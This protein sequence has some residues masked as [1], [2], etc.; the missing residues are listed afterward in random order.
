MQAWDQ[1][2]VCIYI[3]IHN[4]TQSRNSLYNIISY[5]SNDS[6]FDMSME[7]LEWNPS[8]YHPKRHIHPKY[9]GN[10]IRKC[11]SIKTHSFTGFLISIDDNLPRIST[12]KCCQNAIVAATAH[13]SL[14]TMH[15]SWSEAYIFTKRAVSFYG[16]ARFATLVDKIV[17]NILWASSCT[18]SP[19]GPQTAVRTSLTRALCLW[20]SYFLRFVKLTLLT[21]YR[22]I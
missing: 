18:S 5:I 22:L 13:S 10:H 21:T 6:I 16:V 11:P 3:Y 20:T 14:L 12:F 19:N 15:Y 4:R 8:W 17:E 2:A 7:L 1:A 9:I